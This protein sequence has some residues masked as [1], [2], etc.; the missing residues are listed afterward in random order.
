MFHNS[1]KRGISFLFYAKFLV[2]FLVP[3]SG[4][5]TVTILEERKLS[6][7]FVRRRVWIWCGWRHLPCVSKTDP[8]KAGGRRTFAL[9]DSGH[10]Y[11]SDHSHSHWANSMSWHVRR[12]CDNLVMEW[13]PGVCRGHAGLHWREDRGEGGGQGPPGQGGQH[14]GPR[15]VELHRAAQAGAGQPRPQARDPR[16]ALHQPRPQPGEEGG[17]WLPGPDL[18]MLTFQETVS[19]EEGSSAKF[20][21]SASG[22]PLPSVHW[23]RGDTGV[24]V[25]RGPGLSLARVTA[26]MSGTYSCVAANSEGEA[27]QTLSLNVL[28]EWKL[29]YRA[30]SRE[31]RM[32]QHISN[33]ESNFQCIYQQPPTSYLWN[34]I[35]Y[36]SVLL[37]VIKLCSDKP[38]TKFSRKTSTRDAYTSSTLLSC[39]V[40][41]NPRASVSQQKY[42]YL[43]EDCKMFTM[44]RC[45]CT[46]T[47]SSSPA[48]SWGQ[49]RPLSLTSTPWP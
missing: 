43:R 16:G 35:P 25:A 30:K 4:K 41:A 1:V 45:L 28:C 44:L 31:L 32:H 15:R 26:D 9:P 2:L 5:E 10:R 33:T 18:T 49:A 22:F 3:R 12:G 21:C 14:R 11:F 40:Q 29:Q 6:M 13:S 27:S 47:Q 46:K 39:T 37:K 38:R 20:S 8:S 17:W 24:Q 34:D 23:V 48:A 19:L 42:K 36:L 7:V